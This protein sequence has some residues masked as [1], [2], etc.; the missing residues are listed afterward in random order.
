[1]SKPNEK[2][3]MTMIAVMLA[4]TIVIAV[5]GVFLGMKLARPPEANK[6]GEQPAAAPHD[7]EASH[8]SSAAHSTEPPAHV[9]SHK[10]GKTVLKVLE[11]IVTNLANG[12]SSWI[13]LQVA[14]VYSPE[15]IPHP[16]VL[17]SELTAD[18]VAYLHGTSLQAIEGGAGL[19][20]LSEELSERA[21][22]RSEGAVQELIIQSLVVQ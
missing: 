2:N 19:R 21:S 13:R 7:A 17:I 10:P 22:T 20:R 1:M 3:G 9:S 11:P 18:I 4:V 6:P 8:G 16:D 5:A 15:A 14:I 12:D